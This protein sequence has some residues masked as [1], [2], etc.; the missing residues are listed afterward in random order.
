MGMKANGAVERAIRTW[1]DQ[2]RTMQDY[3][4]HRTRTTMQRIGIVSSWLVGWAADVL[5]KYKVQDTGRT[6]FEMLTYH[7]AKHLVVGFCEKVHHFQH[8]LV[9][10]SGYEK[11]VG[12]FVGFNDRCNTY[13]VANE[14]GV[15]ASPHIQQVPD[16]QAYDGELIGRVRVRYY[17]FL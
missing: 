13:L 11:D 14:D 2:H 8:T 3:F 4:E 10:K 17:D 1:R 6:S 15:F 5:N 16:D 12:A 7:K 9:D